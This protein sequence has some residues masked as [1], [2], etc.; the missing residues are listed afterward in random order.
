[1]LAFVLV[2][3]IMAEGKTLISLY[4]EENNPEGK[5]PYI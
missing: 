1:V 4:P 5:N 2:P 3:L